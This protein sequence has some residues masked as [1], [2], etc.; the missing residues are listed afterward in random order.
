MLA[1]P[2]SFAEVQRVVRPSDIL[3]CW[4]Y[5][6]QT[7]SP[8]VDALVQK[9][10]ADILGPFWWPESK[11][12]EDGYRSLPFPFKEVTLPP[13]RFVQKWDM[14]RLAAYMGTW[15]GSQRFR[16]ETGRDPIGEIRDDLAA[17]WGDP[18]QEREVAWTLFLRLGMI[19][20]TKP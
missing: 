9:L 4:T 19:T 17:A 2:T 15:S 16:K 6:L 13:F 14:N 20:G 5:H 8:E 18:D 11:H 10:Y 7:V 1:Y 3:A 12:I